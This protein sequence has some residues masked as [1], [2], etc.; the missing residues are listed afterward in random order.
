V[1]DGKLARFAAGR[2]WSIFRKSADVDN[3]VVAFGTDR[4]ALA[5]P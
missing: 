4:H 2:C 1:A 3:G 5:A